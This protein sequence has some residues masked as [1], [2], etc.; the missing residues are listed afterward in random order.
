MKQVVIIAGALFMGSLIGVS[1]GREPLRKIPDGLVVLTFDDCNKSDRSFVAKV[2]KEKKFGATFYVTEGL[3]FLRNKD[4]YV[5]WKE[6]VELDRMGFEIGNH[7]KTHPHMPRLSPEQMR[8]ELLH[9]E[10]RCK[11]Y[12][13]RKPVTFCYPGF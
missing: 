4:N 3:G 8:N 6:I 12:G 7:T 2:L 10:K 11:E 5:T 13:I 1:S 9:I